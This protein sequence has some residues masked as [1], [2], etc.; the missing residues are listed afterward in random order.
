M[1]LT[2]GDRRIAV[3]GL[4]NVL[5]GDDAFGPYVVRELQARYAFSDDVDV[6]DL[7]TPGIDLTAQL[8]GL[9]ALILVDTVKSAGAPGELRTHRRDDILRHAPPPRLSPHDPSLKEA[10]LM[11][12]FA[13]GGPSEVLLVGVIPESVATG[14]GLRAPVRA[15]VDG[16]L[17]A[18]VRELERLGAAPRPLPPGQAADIWWEA[19]EARLDVAPTV[20][21]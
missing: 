4:G 13:G 17:E 21:A 8:G 10:L 14:V 7:G 2:F 9:S 16:A 3:I 6:Q 12:E 15:A 1:P 20:P 19:E 5:M 18:V 11:A